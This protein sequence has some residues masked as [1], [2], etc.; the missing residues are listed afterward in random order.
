MDEL[1]AAGYLPRTPSD[2]LSY[3]L[4]WAIRADAFDR[5][6]LLV[7][8]GADINAKEATH[9]QTALMVAAGLNRAEVVTLLLDRGVDAT[10]ASKVVDLNALTAPVDADSVTH[11]PVRGPTRVKL[12]PKKI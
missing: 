10:V 5:V 9:G 7:E 2:I 6:K 11:D 3:Q 1:A 4:R 8:N 12:P